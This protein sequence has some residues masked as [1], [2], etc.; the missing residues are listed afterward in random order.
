MCVVY[1]CV[2]MHMSVSAY[3]VHMCVNVCVYVC[4][5]EDHIGPSGAGVTGS[6]ERLVWVL[7]NELLSSR[8]AVSALGP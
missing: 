7:R 8:R 5:P 3:G 4:V 1:T 2:C 6:C